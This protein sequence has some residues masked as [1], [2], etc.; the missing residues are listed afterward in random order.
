[1]I[2][3]KPQIYEALSAILPTY[4]E[5]FVD[6]E[7]KLPYITYFESSNIDDA[8][9]C[10][11]MGYSLQYYSIKI[12]GNGVDELSQTAQSVDKTMRSLGYVRTSRNELMIGNMICIV[13][14]YKG[15][16]FENNFMEEN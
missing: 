16:G 14:I 3:N 1:M 4:Y 6:D 12:W 15:L 13:L 10:E 8:V 7:V 9:T 5:Q 2:Y 11:T